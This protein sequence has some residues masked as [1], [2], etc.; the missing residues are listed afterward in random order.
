MFSL[1][2]KHHVPMCAQVSLRNPF[3]SIFGDLVDLVAE[4]HCVWLT[5]ELA[6]PRQ[7]TDTP[8]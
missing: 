8:Q 5:G 6:L 4:A 7:K 3:A 2:A 1:T